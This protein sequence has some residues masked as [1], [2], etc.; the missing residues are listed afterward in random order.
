L[1]VAKDSS[2]KKSHTASLHK[3]SIVHDCS[4]GGLNAGAYIA[5]W[6]ADSHSDTAQ[7]HRSPIALAP[8]TD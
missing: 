5:Q 8:R 2:A 6:S 3:K 1:N 4:A 7:R